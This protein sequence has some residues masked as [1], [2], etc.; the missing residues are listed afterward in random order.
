MSVIEIIRIDEGIN[1][2]MDN[3]LKYQEEYL[4]NIVID[5]TDNM[6]PDENSTRCPIA[7]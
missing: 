6:Y 7:H 1:L 3:D 2:S 4:G 5:S